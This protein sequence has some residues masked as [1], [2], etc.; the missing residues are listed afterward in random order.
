MSNATVATLL[1]F[2]TTTKRIK[3][4][5]NSWKATISTM[6]SKW[7][8]MDSKRKLSPRT[9]P[10]T[11]IGF[12]EAGS[13]RVG[14]IKMQLPTDGGLQTSTIILWT[15]VRNMALWG[16]QQRPGWLTGS[17]AMF[18]EDSKS[19]YTTRPTRTSTKWYRK[20]RRSQSSKSRGCA[21]TAERSTKR[22]C[23]R[24]TGKLTACSKDKRQS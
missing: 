3:A 6:R 20:A 4:N 10:S 17:S 13:L 18:T 15:W 16:S 19:K 23:L 22:N 14:S 8:K 2:K 21:P 1:L 11:Q 12:P 24:T 9:T 7:S 5:W